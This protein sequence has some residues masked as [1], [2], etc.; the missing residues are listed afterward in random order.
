VSV[1]VYERLREFLD[2]LPGGYP[3]TESGVE[4]KILKKLFAPEDAEM[5]VCLTQFP[6]PV[7]AIAG[8]SGMEE[9]EA[10]AILESMA[11]RGLIFRIRMGDDIF[12]MANMFVVGIYEFNV[13][14]LDRELAEMMEEYLPFLTRSL[15]SIKT[16]QLRV[17][18]VG[19]AIDAKPSVATYDRIR[20]LVKNQE[21]AAVA[22]CICRKEKWLLDCGCDRPLETCLLFGMGAE[23]YIENGI[24]RKITIEEALRILDL[25]EE[26][27][28]VLMS[29]NAVDILNICCCCKCCCGSLMMLSAGGQPAAQMQ[30]SYQARIDPELCAAC[31]TCLDRCQIEAIN[32]RDEFMEIDTVRCI[33]CGLCVTSCPEEAISLDERTDVGP[34]PANIV[35][36]KMRMAQEWET[37]L[38]PGRGQPPLS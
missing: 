27:A 24:G 15:G 19:A 8:R 13:N 1:D 9:P 33:G 30:S 28:L 10:G 37:R 36:M 32:E 6:E 7:S 29:T 5:A 26:S 4:I 31:A 14:S 2:S 20:E 38:T 12:Y 11:K 22:P 35:E 23:Y 21:V 18:P 25:A 17:V 16:K 3:E 34:P